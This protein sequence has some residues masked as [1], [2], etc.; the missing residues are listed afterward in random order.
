MDGVF[1]GVTYDAESSTYV[2]PAGSQSWAGVANNNQD[3]YPINLG[4]GGKITFTAAAPS[5]DVTVAFRYERLP[6]GGDAGEPSYNTEA[7]TIS[8]TEEKEYTI[9]VPAQPADRTYSS[10]LLYVGEPFNPT[11]DTPVVVKDVFVTGTVVNAGN[12]GG[13]ASFT[14]A[15][16]GT[17]ISEDGTQFTWPTGAQS[18]GGFANMNADIYPMKLGGGATIKFTGAASA[19]DVDVQFRFERLPGGGDASEPSYN[20]DVVT[21]SGTADTEYT[22]NVPAQDASNT[23]SSF[24][25]YVKTVDV[26]ATVKDVV[27]TPAD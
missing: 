22:I 12:G 19:G 18:W 3:L 23:Y 4:D 26:P 5:G 1:G 24:I 11:Y 14:E 27:V 2:V 25:M 9:D 16:G 20:T 6:G 8:G 21:I 15:F 10:F 17:T 7:V 13:T